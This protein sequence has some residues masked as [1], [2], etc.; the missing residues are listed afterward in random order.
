MHSIMYLMYLII[1]IVIIMYIYNYLIPNGVSNTQPTG[2]TE[3]ELSSTAFP[4]RLTTGSLVMEVP[5]V[6]VFW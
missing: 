4:E 2:V 6:V 5:L 3:K 1:I